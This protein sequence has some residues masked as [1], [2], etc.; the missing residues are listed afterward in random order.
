P[1][2]NLHFTFERNNIKELPVY[3]DKEQLSRA[4]LN[5]IK[6]GIQSIPAEQIGKI[7]IT[8]QN[9]QSMAKVSISDNGTGISQEAQ[10]HLFQ[11]NFTTKTSGMGLGLSIVQNIIQ[12]CGG[13]ITYV[14]SITS[15]TTFFIEIPIYHSTT[16]HENKHS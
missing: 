16:V 15:G 10:E 4:F 8:V 9:N 12:S 14:T 1:N 2:E 6:N 7:D 13:K 5:L 3:A 11:P